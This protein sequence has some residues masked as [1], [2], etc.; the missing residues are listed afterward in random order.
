MQQATSE[1]PIATGAGKGVLRFTIGAALALAGVALAFSGT[2]ASLVNVW[3]T[4]EEY[5]YGYIVPF[6]FA[7][8]IYQRLHLLRE[9][10]TQ[11]R[12]WALPVCALGMAM[13]A[14]GRLSTLDTIAQYG[15][16]AVVWSAFLA[17]L[18]WPAFRKLLVPMAVL[19]FMVPIPN[20]LLRELSASLQLISSALGVQL[21]RW[22]GISVYLEGNVI[23]L[24][25]MKLQVV[26]ACSGLRYLFSLLVLSFLVAYFYRGRLWRRVLVFVSAVP[27]TVLMNSVRIALVGVTVDHFGRKAAEG[28]LH[29]FEGVTI[30][31]G[32]VLILLAEIWVMTALTRPR[33]AFRDVFALDIPSYDW[34]R[35]VRALH[36]VGAPVLLWLGAVWLAGLVAFTAPERAHSKPVRETFSTFPLEIAGARGYLGR[37]EADV[38]QLLKHDD[39][40]L[41]NYFD[42]QG[43]AIN[44]YASYYASQSDGNGVHSPRACIPGDGW[45]IQA[46][47]THALSAVR[48]GASSLIVNRAVIQKGENRALVYYWFQQRGR[49]VTGEYQVKLYLLWDSLLR[50]RTDGAMVR[51]VAPLDRGEPIESAERR[52]DAF[53]Q[54]AMAPLRRFIPE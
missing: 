4:Q 26:E 53:A 20:Y 37:L 2:L 8:L 36:P 24:G 13:I 38:Q 43:H 50:G 11:G 7:F 48:I 45:E 22:C 15:L 30:F 35:L 18:G 19:A 32:C 28:L 34:N 12:W 41:V 52:L 17:Y 54:S 27:V 6:V 21:I 29:D 49:F 10:S 44:L 51:L 3:E 46:F 39:Y 47:G 9:R 1:M 42:A 33:R 16:L 25:S 40:L 14:L 31:L 5:S 23:D